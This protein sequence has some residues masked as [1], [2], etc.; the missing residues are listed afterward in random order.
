MYIYTYV[1]IYTHIYIRMCVWYLKT[2]FFYIYIP[3]E[4]ICIYIYT[5]ILLIHIYF[6]HDINLPSHRRAH[7]NQEHGLHCEPCSAE[8]TDVSGCRSLRGTM[9]S[10]RSDPSAAWKRRRY[11][12][13]FIY[14]YIYNIYIYIRTYISPGK[15]GD[16]LK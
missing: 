15:T 8:P 12:L 16:F 10:G 4:D 13:Y 14:L 2:C 9:T 7:Q 11:H 3:I 6:F 5:Y 1:Y